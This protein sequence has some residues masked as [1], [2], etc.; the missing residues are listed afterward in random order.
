M[1][2]ATARLTLALFGLAVA[3]RCTS[4]GAEAP[5]EDGGADGGADG[6]DGAPS[7][8]AASDAAVFSFDEGFE[9]TGWESAWS[10]S[11]APAVAPKAVA[12]RGRDGGFA[13]EVSL[14]KDPNR[15]DSYISRQIPS[16]NITKITGYMMVDTL[17]NGEVDFFGVPIPLISGKGAWIIHQDSTGNWALEASG[18]GVNKILP[19]VMKGVWTQM[20][21]TITR[22][23]PRVEWVV[24]AARGDAPL[25]PAAVAGPLTLYVGLTGFSPI[26]VPWKV[27]Y[28]DISVTAE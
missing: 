17:G 26:S 23:P 15:K 22:T 8:A 3:V 7:D 16:R 27:L 5:N 13:L 28:D 24:G 9:A 25:E 10:L 12:G 4:F 11:Q 21:L 20:S 14:D 18:G 19:A 2:S 1:Q 6:S